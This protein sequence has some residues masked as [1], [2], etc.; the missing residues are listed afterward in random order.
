VLAY[1]KLTNS[2]RVGN[3]IRDG[4]LNGLRAMI[5]PVQRTPFLR[6]VKRRYTVEHGTRHTSAVG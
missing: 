3:A 2:M 4:Q 6:V 5:V 1:E